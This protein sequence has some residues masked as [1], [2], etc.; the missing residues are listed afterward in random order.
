MLVRKRD[1]RIIEFNK[2]KISLAIIKAMEEV[3]HVNERTALRIANEIS[4]LDYENLVFLKD[5]PAHNIIYFNKSRLDS[6]KKVSLK[7][8]LKIPADKVYI[9]ESID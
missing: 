9:I 2:E 4:K 1:G 6:D 7:Y 8:T 5:I 3:H